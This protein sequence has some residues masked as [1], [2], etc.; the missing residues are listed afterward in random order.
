M[1]KQRVALRSESVRIAEKLEKVIDRPEEA[2][3]EPSVVGSRQG[4]GQTLLGLDPEHADL[5]KV[6][7][8]RPRWTRAEAEQLCVERS[9]MVDG[10]LERINE[11]AFA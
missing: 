7:L 4:G 6:L 1:K 3:S 8:D 10:A 9:L 11:A 5:L 2:I